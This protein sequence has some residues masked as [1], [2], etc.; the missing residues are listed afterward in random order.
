MRQGLTI[1]LDS[2]RLLHAKKLFW[3]T[4]AITLMVALA[5]A[6]IGYYENGTSLFFGLKKIDN[7]ILV[8][9]SEE[10]AAFHLLLFTDV[11]VKFWLAWFAIM[12]AL[13]STASIFPNFLK[14]GAIVIAAMSH[15]ERSAKD[16]KEVARRLLLAL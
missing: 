12:L 9:G 3:I 11:I 5:Y 6:S 8:K 4:F 10:A 1:L 2:F 16:A 15:S 13:I 14:E 7:E